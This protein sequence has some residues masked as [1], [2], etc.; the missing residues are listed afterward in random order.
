MLIHCRDGKARR[1]SAEPGVQPLAYAISRS[2]G[3]G[4]PEL[5]RLARRARSNRVGRLKGYGNAIVPTVAAV[6]VQAVMD[7]LNLKGEHADLR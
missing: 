6:F 5:G 4:I 1:V 7:V 2:V 3:R